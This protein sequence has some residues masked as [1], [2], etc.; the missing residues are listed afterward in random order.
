MTDKALYV[1]IFLVRAKAYTEKKKAI[2]VPAMLF[3]KGEL[4]RGSVDIHEVF[5]CDL[6]DIVYPKG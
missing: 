6:I 2:P 3:G 4:M 5:V 1:Y